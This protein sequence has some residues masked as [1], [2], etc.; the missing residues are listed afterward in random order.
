M[1]K[2]GANEYNNLKNLSEDTRK[3]VEKYIHVPKLV[4]ILWIK[5]N[6]P[7]TWKHIGDLR[8]LNL[9]EFIFFKCFG[10]MRW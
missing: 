10:H 9:Q 4:K 1:D 2:R 3:V 8:F 7:S 5:K 6:L